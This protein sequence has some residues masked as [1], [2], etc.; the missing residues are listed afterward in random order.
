MSIA[1]RERPR[2]GVNEAQSVQAAV[3]SA[4]HH[5]HDVGPAKDVVLRG[6]K[7]T[8]EEGEAGLET[9]SGL[10]APTLLPPGMRPARPG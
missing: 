8:T 7:K 4:L 3:V 2:G 6:Q 9:H 1:Q 10:R 5:S